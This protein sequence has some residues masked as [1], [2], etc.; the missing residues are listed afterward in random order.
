MGWLLSDMHKMC[1]ARNEVVH[2]RV[3]VVL[4]HKDDEEAT[5]DITLEHKQGGG[6]YN[7]SG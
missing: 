1:L 3:K 6:G 2:D 4:H 5:S 7:F